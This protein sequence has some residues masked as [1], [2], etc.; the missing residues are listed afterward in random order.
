RETFGVIG[1]TGS[2]KTTLFSMLAGFQSPTCGSISLN[3]EQIQGLGAARVCEKGIA[4]TF[5]L[6]QLFGSFSVLETVVAGALLRHDNHAANESALRILREIGLMP[7]K[8]S[9]NLTL[10]DRRRLEV[11]R[12]LA[13][14]PTVVLLDE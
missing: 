4:R 3:G 10:A 11:A 5:Q 14:D 8:G 6:P 1:P 12:A 9:A 13:T 2:G 7:N